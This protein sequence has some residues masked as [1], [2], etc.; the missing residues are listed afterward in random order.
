MAVRRRS[1][2]GLFLHVR[3]GVTGT[4][5]Q[6]GL[7]EVEV[8]PGVW[9]IRWFS[10][11]TGAPGALGLARVEDMMKWD[12]YDDE[13]RWREIGDAEIVRDRA[14]GEQQ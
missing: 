13:A 5:Q 6:Q 4:I 12:F 3:N 14:K 1:L 8:S 10:Y 7:V 2:S 9:L 11:V